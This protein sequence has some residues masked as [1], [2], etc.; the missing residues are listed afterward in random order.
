MLIRMRSPD[1]LHSKICSKWRAFE[2]T[3][4]GQTI[5]MLIILVWLGRLALYYY[6]SGHFSKLY[7]VFK[8]FLL[9]RAFT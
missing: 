2:L 6:I 4:N 1:N 3:L 7:T 9:R 8:N 5:S